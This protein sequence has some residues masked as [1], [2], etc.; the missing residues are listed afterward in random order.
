MCKKK[1]LKKRNKLKYEFKIV[2]SYQYL[3]YPIS[4]K[5]LL[6][7]IGENKRNKFRKGEK[8]LKW[9]KMYRKSA[10]TDEK[11]K[12]TIYIGVKTEFL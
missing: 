10:K 9:L 8:R 1:A 7:Q 4:W 3:I 6:G 2:I 11:K 12:G 5:L